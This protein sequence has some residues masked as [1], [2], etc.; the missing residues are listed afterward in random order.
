MFHI[1][2][3]KKYVDREIALKYILN[4]YSC[5]CNASVN[6]ISNKLNLVNIINE[7]LNRSLRTC[8]QFCSYLIPL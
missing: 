5:L 7:A 3:K 6:V 8:E 1:L 2:K 4:A